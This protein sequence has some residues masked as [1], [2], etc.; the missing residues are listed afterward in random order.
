MTG[1]LRSLLFVPGNRPEMLE[2]ALGLKPDAIVPDMED[3]V[4]LTEKEE[5]RKTVAEYLPRLAEAGPLVLPRVNSQDTGLLR[6]DLAAVVGPYIYGVTVGKVGSAAE[7]AV[8][9]GI[10]DD[11]EAAA[12]LE[13]GSEKLVPWAETARGI[14]NAYEICSASPRI[15]AVAFGAEDFTNDMA[16]E[17]TGDDSEV[18][19]ARSAVAVAARAAGVT[20]LDTP[21]VRYQDADGLRADAEASRKVGFRGKFAIH[22]S[23]IDVINEAYA[24]TEG[25]VQE[26][27][28]VVAAFEEAERAGR[29]A[30]SLDGRMIDAPVVSRARKL[31]DLARAAGGEE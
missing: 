21:Y 27:R 9:S 6:D 16:I 11:L 5:A 12:G 18:V 26:A 2:K 19:Y 17:R 31:L 23:Q 14:V 29:G 1:V 28:R 15:V 8:V 25:E 30:T 4:P 24:P 20:A 13:K 3:S 10:L 7:V 22:P